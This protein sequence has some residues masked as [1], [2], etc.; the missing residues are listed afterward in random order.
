M[1]KALDMSYYPS[2]P[3]RIPDRYPN[4]L[5]QHEDGE[6]YVCN[7][8]TKDSEPT[9]VEAWYPTGIKAWDF[10]QSWDSDLIGKD[11][12]DD[13]IPGIYYCL[14]HLGRRSVRIVLINVGKTIPRYVTEESVPE[15]KPKGKGEHVVCWK[16][17]VW[18]KL[19]FLKNSEKWIKV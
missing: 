18:W 6:L 4:V 9:L 19:K 8:W 13:S 1:T 2:I 15:P 17:G 16:H 5:R 7:K 3:Y 14:N 12:E 10:K 11:L